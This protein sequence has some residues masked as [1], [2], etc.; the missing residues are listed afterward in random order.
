MTT[1]KH[2]LTEKRR[3]WRLCGY[4]LLLLG[5]AAL[6]RMVALVMAHGTRHKKTEDCRRC[7][8]VLCMARVHP[9]WIKNNT[10]RQQSTEQAT[11]DN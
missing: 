5:I 2:Q 3:R 9:R 7:S 8:C 10:N 11:P 6:Q 4:V 1:T